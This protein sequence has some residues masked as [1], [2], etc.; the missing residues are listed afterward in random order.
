[1]LPALLQ[2][3]LVAIFSFITGFFGFILTILCLITCWRSEKLR[4]DFGFLFNQTISKLFVT[5]IFFVWISPITYIQQNET[6]GGIFGKFI[7]QVLVINWCAFIYF[8]VLET[9]NHFCS[10]IYPNFRL[11]LLSQQI[12][13]PLCIFVWLISV[14]QNIPMFL[15]NDCYMFYNPTT[16]LFDFATTSCGDTLVTI[17]IYR[18]MFVA[19]IFIAVL[20]MI[21]LIFVV[22]RDGRINI[23]VFSRDILFTL[24]VVS[25]NTAMKFYQE[26]F[27]IFLFTT[28]AWIIQICFDALLI[29]IFN[30]KKN[31]SIW[32]I[33]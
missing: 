25:F 22:S 27:Y 11:K 1:M 2:I 9:I 15:Y 5:I 4:N 12:P 32:R 19:F 28:F 8:Q 20:D 18:I 14:F 17:V 3:L 31:I 13:V 7:G 16:F 29:L 6:G 21:L 10:M 30:F 23:E 33:T 24:L 26:N